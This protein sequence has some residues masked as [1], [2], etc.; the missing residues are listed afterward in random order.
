MTPPVGSVLFV[1]AAIG[2]I[3]IEDAVKTIWPFYLALIA[4]LLLTAYV[5]ALTLALPEL[6]R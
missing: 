4:A 3:R 2:R 1:G 5:P 6:L